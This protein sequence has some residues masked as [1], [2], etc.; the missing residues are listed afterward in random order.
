MTKQTE[1]RTPE[2]LEDRYNELQH[3]L[4]DE[5]GSR[6]VARKQEEAEAAFERCNDL[7]RA[8]TYRVRETGAYSEAYLTAFAEGVAALEAIHA[9]EPTEAQSRRFW[10]TGRW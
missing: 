9:A 6:W 1:T 7:V 10:T 3:L 5:P 4:M 2:Q 8:G